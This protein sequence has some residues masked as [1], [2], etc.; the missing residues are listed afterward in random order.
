MVVAL[1]SNVAGGFASSEA[2][3]EAALARF[4]E[5]GLPVL[6]RSSWWRSAAWP[7]PKG[8]EYRNGVALVEAKAGSDSVL[9]ALFSIERHFGRMRDVRNA[10]RTL[11][12]DLIAYGREVKDAPR[13]TL[14]H[15][16]AHE[17]RFVMGPLAEIAPGWTHPVLGRTAAQLAASAAVGRDAEPV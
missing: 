1:G 17:R 3:L 14:P 13:L 10:P 11:D 7:D 15:P 9:E 2:L 12:L 6:E 5:A 8:P 4:P 16:R